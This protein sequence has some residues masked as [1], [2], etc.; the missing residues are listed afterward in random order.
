MAFWNRPEAYADPIVQAGMS[1]LALLPETARRR[2]A[3]R[4]LADIGSGEWDRRHGHLRA[5]DRFDGG[6]RLA[7]CGA[8]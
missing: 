8:A 2:G 4:L 6:Y 7:I 5:L 3:E 1:W